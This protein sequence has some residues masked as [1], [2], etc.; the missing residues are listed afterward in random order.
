M[1]NF[2]NSSI[3]ISTVRGE[4]PE[5]NE[6]TIS[7]LPLSNAVNCVI[8]SFSTSNIVYVIKKEI[9]ESALDDRNPN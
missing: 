1:A 5:R 9:G 7:M 2:C 8:V 3:L 6:F 4:D